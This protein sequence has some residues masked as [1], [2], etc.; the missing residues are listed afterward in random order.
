VIPLAVHCDAAETAHGWGLG[1]VVFDVDAPILVAGERVGVSELHVGDAERLALDMARDIARLLGCDVIHYTDRLDIALADDVVWVPRRRNQAAD[2]VAR[3]ASAVMGPRWLR[4]ERVGQ[5][6]A[7]CQR[8]V[9][10]DRRH[11]LYNLEILE[12]R[13]GWR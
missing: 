10:R 2:A 3:L 13:T 12:A 6:L 9:P 7:W 11:C 4:H 5:Y 8:A 1:V